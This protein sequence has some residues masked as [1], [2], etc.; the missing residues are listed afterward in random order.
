MRRCD[1]MSRRHRPPAAQEEAGCWPATQCLRIA[2]TFVL[3]ANLSL[4]IPMRSPLEMNGPR[5]TWLTLGA[6]LISIVT[7][8]C[9]GASLG[10]TTPTGPIVKDAAVY[11]MSN[12]S[13]G[14][15]VMM[16]ASAADGTLQAAG[17]VQT[18]GRGTGAGIE[19]QGALS[20]TEDGKFL[21]VVNPASDDFSLFR[22]AGSGPQLLSTTPS[23]GKRPISIS[24]R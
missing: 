4:G 24:A 11:S 17:S 1:R 19:N 3:C 5:N 7:A 16:F 18:G 9:S 10:V 13:S 12:S 22:L 20:V 23:G 6:V 15:A 21:L 14:N 8:S 2:V